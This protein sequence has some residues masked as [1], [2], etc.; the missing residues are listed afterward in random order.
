MHYFV[1]YK[2]VIGLIQTHNAQ[3]YSSI[4]TTWL[5]WIAGGLLIT[6]W[7]KVAV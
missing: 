6:H 4:I 7:T 5:G 1:F 2:N 3:H